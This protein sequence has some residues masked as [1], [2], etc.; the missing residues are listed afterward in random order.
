M[1]QRR[2]WPLVVNGQYVM[3]D[4]GRV[5]VSRDLDLGPGPVGQSRHRNVG[6]VPLTDAVPPKGLEGLAAYASHAR[7]R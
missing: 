5:V 7:G 3:E 1:I 4:D 6:A 2:R